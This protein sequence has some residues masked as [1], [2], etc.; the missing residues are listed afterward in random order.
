[1]H[2]VC[3]LLAL[4]V[5]LL[6][7][8][9]AVCPQ[10]QYLP[11]RARQALEHATAFFT[12]Q[13]ATNGGYLWSY[14]ADL[15]ERWGETKANDHLIWVQPPGTP[16]VG[17][18]YLD[19]YRA[20]GDQRYLDA[21]LAAAR[22]LVWGQLEVGGW[23]YLVDFSEEADRKWAYRRHA[24]DGRPLSEKSHQRATFDDDTSQSALRFLIA[25]DQATAD[26]R[27]HDAAR[28]ALD[29]FLKAQFANGAWP[30]WYP[31]S[32]T[33]YSRWYTFNDGAI[34]DCIATMIAAYHAY[35]DDRY[36]Q[37]ALR[38][39]D[40]IILSQYKAPQRRRS[41]AATSARW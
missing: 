40:F 30:Q 29:F 21:A 38:G 41:P 23:D 5:L 11:T 8:Q 16:S 39:G 15:S 12:T 25:V 34:N 19:A 37:S 36:L 32:E 31:L 35:G 18:A 24:N 28:Y 6:F 17:F 3:C 2:F 14:S 26:P 1:M 10:G 7:A 13:V 4:P 27:I 22:A 33:D 20:T 9:G